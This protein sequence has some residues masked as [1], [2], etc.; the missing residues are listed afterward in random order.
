MKIKHLIEELELFDKDAEV[1]IARGMYCHHV[2]RVRIA[3]HKSLH[4]DK[5]PVYIEIPAE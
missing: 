2:T 5:N 4:D 1:L 3:N